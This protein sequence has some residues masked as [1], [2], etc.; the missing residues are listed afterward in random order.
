VYLAWIPAGASPGMIQAGAGM[1][2]RACRSPMKKILI[3]IILALA[4]IA[5]HHLTS[6]SK[7]LPPDKI[8][9]IESYLKTIVVDTLEKDYHRHNINITALVT[10]LKTYRIVKKKGPEY[11][12]YAAQGRVSYIIKGKREWQDQEGN[13]IRLDPET[14][15]TH[16]F[17]CEIYEDPYGELFKDKYRNRL[18]FY[19]D[20]PVKQ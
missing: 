15:I 1:T 4:V 6:G 20:D 12:I 14:E 16:W 11:I 9:A 13:R 8:A 10:H 7:A 18:V 5:V 2:D 3:L 17:G 19:A